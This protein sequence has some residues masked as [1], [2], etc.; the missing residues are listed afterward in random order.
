MWRAA[1]LGDQFKGQK[2]L[3]VFTLTT[4][5]GFMLNDWLCLKVRF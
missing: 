3:L 5:A 2:G 4:L 1:T